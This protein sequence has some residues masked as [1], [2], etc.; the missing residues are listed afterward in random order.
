MNKRFKTILLII[1]LGIFFFSLY[2][3]VFYFI[4]SNNNKKSTNNLIEKAIVFE[5]SNE[6][7]EKNEYELPFTVDFNVLKQQNDDIVGWIYSEDTPINNPVLQSDD[8]AYY[9]RKLITGEYN[10]GGSLFMDYRNDSKIQNNNTIIY[11]HNMK[12]GTMFGSLK[13]YKNQD[14]YEA[15]KLMYYFTPEKNYLVRVFSACTVS[16]NSSIYTFNN[17]PQ[18]TIDNIIKKSNFTSDVVVTKDDKILTLSTC[19]YEYNDARYIVLGKLEEIPNEQ[20][21]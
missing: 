6:D 18:S 14:Y 4:E 16:A 10:S 8:N 12:N 7:K 1:F 3:V 21:D 17:L 9:L 13:K 15:H 2:K 11:G 19:S 20:L 5:E